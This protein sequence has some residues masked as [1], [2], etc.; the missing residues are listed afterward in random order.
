VPTAKHGE[1]YAT[2]TLLLLIVFGERVLYI[3]V[4]FNIFH[5]AYETNFSSSYHIHSARYRKPI[6]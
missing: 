5:R 3:I 6:S 4:Y 2:V 1:I